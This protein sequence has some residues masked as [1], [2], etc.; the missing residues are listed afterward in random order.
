MTNKRENLPGDDVG[1]CIS[2]IAVLLTLPKIYAK[3]DPLLAENN[4]ESDN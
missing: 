4:I 2:T 3:N 1:L